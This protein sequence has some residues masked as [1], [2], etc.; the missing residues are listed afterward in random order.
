MDQSKRPQKYELLGGRNR[1]GKHTGLLGYADGM[2]KTLLTLLLATMVGNGFQMLGFTEAN[3]ITVYILGV[4]IV[5]II[6]TNQLC[7]LLASVGS[8]LIFN[9]FFTAPRFTFHFQDNSYPVTFVLCLL[10]LS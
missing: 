3:I 4:L 5:S 6:T 1:E 2:G 7:S 10:P 9:F 8:V